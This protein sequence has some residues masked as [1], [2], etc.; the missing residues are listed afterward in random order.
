MT[1]PTVTTSPTSITSNWRSSIISTTTSTFTQYEPRITDWLRIP[2]LILSPDELS[3]VQSLIS[4]LEDELSDLQSSTSHTRISFRKR[5]K[6]TLS[7]KYNKWLIKLIPKSHTDRAQDSSIVT[8][9]ALQ[10]SLDSLRSLSAPIRRLP[11]ELLSEIFT[12]CLPYTDQGPFIRPCAHTAPLLLTQVCAAWRITALATPALW[13]S[14]AI[15]RTD[16]APC[17]KTTMPMLRTWLDRSGRCPLSVSFHADAFPYAALDEVLNTHHARFENM[18][19]TTGYQSHPVID[20]TKTFVKLKSFDLRTPYELPSAIEMRFSDALSGAKSLEHFTWLNTSSTGRVR[21]MP[22][23][24]PLGALTRLVLHSPCDVKTC[25]EIMKEAGELRYVAVNNLCAGGVYAGMVRMR[26]LSQF[27]IDTFQFTD[28]LLS[29]LTLPALKDFLL[30]IRTWE[31]EAVT[32]LI[33]RSQCPLESINIYFADITETQI[34]D[35]LRMTQ[36]TLREFTIQTDPQDMSAAKPFGDA[37][38]EALMYRPDADA[39]ALCPNLDTIALYECIACSE[40]TLEK[41]LVSRS[42]SVVMKMKNRSSDSPATDSTQDLSLSSLS[43]SL[44]SS[45]PKPLR[46]L[47][48]YDSP[49]LRPSL[50]ALR[51]SGLLVRLFSQDNKSMDM[52]RDDEERLGRLVKEEG[53]FVRLYDPCTGYFDVPEGHY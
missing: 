51:A 35:V 14:L 16:K 15:T 36:T 33:A 22:F 38:C 53:L 19:L 4:E 28:V 3:D 46:L 9:M 29:H 27:I 48:S 1:T 21:G 32:S 43:L 6:S 49:S 20:A 18:R 23:E 10:K 11:P 2:G 45:P 39:D 30:N 50:P 12:H 31:H 37:V 24:V 47:Q 41:M 7:S 25:L 42:E 40:G 13:A 26:H 44:E 34:L 5:A 52:P 17:H 8:Q